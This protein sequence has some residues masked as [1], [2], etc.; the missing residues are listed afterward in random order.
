[1]TCLATVRSFAPVG[2]VAAS[3]GP[4]GTAS[5]RQGAGAV[6]RTVGQKRLSQRASTLHALAPDA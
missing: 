6:R 4:D 5:D 1:M 3:E 2:G